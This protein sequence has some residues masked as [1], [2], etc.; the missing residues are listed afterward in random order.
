METRLRTLIIDANPDFC[1]TFSTYLERELN[2]D[3]VGCPHDGLSALR[4]LEEKR[5]ELVIM[6]LVLPKLDGLELLRRMQEMKLSTRILVLSSFISEK[7]IDSC[8]QYGADYFM[9]KPCGTEAVAAHINALF[10]PQEST[11]HS[12]STVPQEN[13]GHTETDRPVRE[14]PD[15]RAVPQE[16]EIHTANAVSPISAESLTGV[17]SV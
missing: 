5:P 3:I 11:V 17:S 15:S 7:V 2:I 10:A 8:S 16:E 6:D 13:T 14:D 1:T 9:Q 12:E 4:E